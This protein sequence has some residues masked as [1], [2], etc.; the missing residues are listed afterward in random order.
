MQGEETLEIM[1][2]QG[3]TN[4]KLSPF[5][6]CVL[7]SLTW[8]LMTLLFFA[9][10]Y[11]DALVKV[12]QLRGTHSSFLSW[13][14]LQAA[15]SQVNEQ[16][17]EETDREYPLRQPSSDKP[18]QTAPLRQPSSD[19]PPQTTPLRQPPSGSPVLPLFLFGAAVHLDV[20]FRGPRHQPHQ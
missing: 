5:G 13:N 1:V 10:S 2:A 7:T 20:F 18:P 6:G 4:L 11:F 16:V 14:D 8:L 3:G 9:A 15:V 19:N 12:R 17:Q